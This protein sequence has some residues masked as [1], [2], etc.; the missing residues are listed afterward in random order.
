M[1]SAL[2]KTT[3]V[4]DYLQSVANA[5]FLITAVLTTGD[6]DSKSFSIVWQTYVRS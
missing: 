1:L 2:G 5:V 4:M 6:N 3:A